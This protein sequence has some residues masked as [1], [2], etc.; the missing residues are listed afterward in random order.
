MKAILTLLI[1]V[2]FLIVSPLQGARKISALF[3]PENVAP[4]VYDF[5]I[6]PNPASPK[7]VYLANLEDF[8][9]VGLYRVSP[10]GGPSLKIS[11]TLAPGR[12]IKQFRLSPDGL[13]TVFTAEGRQDDTLDLYSV[14]TDGGP[15]TQLNKEDLGFGQQVSSFQITPDNVKVVYLADDVTLGVFN[16][17]MVV[18]IGGGAQPL[19]ITANVDPNITIGTDFLISPVNNQVVYLADQQLNTTNEVFSAAIDGGGSI[20]LNNTLTTT[21]DARFMVLTQNGSNVVYTAQETGDP[22]GIYQASIFTPQSSVQIAFIPAMSAISKIDVSAT[23]VTYNAFIGVNIY[24]LRIAGL[25]GGVS[26]TFPLNWGPDDIFETDFRFSVDGKSVLYTDFEIPNRRL[27]SLDAANPLAVPKQISNLSGTGTGLTNAANLV[28]F[29]SS[30]DGKWAIYRAAQEALGRFE[31]YR[32]PIQGGVNGKLSGSVGSGGTVLKFKV[33]PTSVEGNQIVYIA[34]VGQAGFPE[35]YSVGFDFL[36]D[37]D[38][39]G[40]ND[41]LLRRGKQLQFLGRGSDGQYSVREFGPLIELG[42][43]EKT[44]WVNDVDGDNRPDLSIKRGKVTE[45]DQ[46]TT[47]LQVTR[48]DNIQIPILPKGFRITATSRVGSDAV[49][50]ATKKKETKVF[51]GAT[52]VLTRLNEGG[53]KPIGFGEINKIPNL[54]LYNA[55]TRALSGVPVI[56]SESNSLTFGETIALGV[57]PKKFKKPANLGKFSSQESVDIVTRQKKNVFLFPL[58]IPEGNTGTLIGTLLGKTQIAGPK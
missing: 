42:T 29:V 2:F 11:G 18:P 19:P 48:N 49:Y 15:V 30:A 58:P 13:W 28:D 4:Q 54:V 39:D 21:G 52:N 44:G 35:L 43:G 33:S 36:S 6:S 37:F 16:N 1:G 50:V 14:L 3:N 46:V 26:Q 56:G 34:K 5:E 38:S 8:N 57:L 40:K 31:V 41:I 12:I 23:Q 10:G 47:D 32:T 51:F 27:F 7:V 45:I 20:K 9:V 17:L 53:S 25:D 55:K 22:S 24:Q